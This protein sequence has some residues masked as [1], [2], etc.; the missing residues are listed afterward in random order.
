[1]ITIKCNKCRSKIFRYLKI[2]EGK[3]LHLWKDR[4]QKD[5]SHRE[6]D[7]VLCECGNEIGVDNGKSIDLNQSA[8]FYTGNVLK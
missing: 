1:M 3:V 4:I 8:F 7:I 5:Y 6:G 2:G